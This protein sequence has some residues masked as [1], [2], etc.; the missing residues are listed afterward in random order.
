MTVFVGI[1][2][3]DSKFKGYLHQIIMVILINVPTIS[4]GLA[5]GWVSLASGEGQ[6]TDETE[7][8]VAAA[9]TFGAS[10][11]GVPISARAIA[12][13]RKPAVI[14]ISAAFV[15]C[16][17]LKLMGD[18]WWLVA[19]RIAAG[20]GG[21]GAWSVSPL[22]AR[23][24]CELKF[25]GAAVAAS[26]LAHNI[27]FLLMYLAADASL[28]HRSS[29]EARK[30]LAWLRGVHHEDPSLV[31][32]MDSLPLPEEPVQSPIKLTKEMLSDVNRR[33]AFVVSSIAVIGQEMCGVFALLQ[34]AERVFVLTRDHSEEDNVLVTP[35]RH[36]VI[37]GVVQLIASAV[38][39]YLVERIGRRPLLVV[40]SVS[41]GICLTTAAIAVWLGAAS[42]WAAALLAGAVAFDSA[43]MQPAP[44]A[45]LA[46][47]FHYQYRGCALMIVSALG[48]IG[49]ASEMFI[50]PLVTSQWG[51]EAALG[52][53]GLLTSA[54]AVFVIA[55]VPETKGK[56]PE[57]IYGGR[58]NDEG[59]KNKCSEQTTMGLLDKLSIW[60]GK[61][62]TEVT[63]LVLGLDN[64][65]KSTLLNTLRPQEQRAQYLGPTVAN[66]QEQFSSGGVS[67]TAWDVSGAPR[68]RALWER[69]YRRAHAVIFVVDSA[70]HLRLVVAREELELMLAHPDMF[71][72]RIPLLVFANKCDSPH[73]LAPMQI[74]AA[75]CLER[76]TDKP[77]HICAS[78]ALSGAGLADGVA[79]LAR[80]IRD[81]HLPH[82][83]H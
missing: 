79:W 3:K 23:E 14:G 20:L 7:V 2:I 60:L 66:Q 74:A 78:N 26:V 37:L 54:Y 43:G 25:R 68:H 65:G 71:G 69:H 63:V 49:N 80:Q 62:R 22:L 17:T 24:M 53:A 34:F 44:Y 1:E 10:F 36:A 33:K 18:G 55:A 13:G 57:E 72:R 45:L 40:C 61:G 76:V 39:L 16:W 38:A 51:I 56:T 4:F 58:N 21:A 27:G 29:S 59:T 42:G 15:V 82:D 46:D 19:A 28:Q 64:S 81:A 50:F 41:T 70:D 5:M 6:S 30:S 32:E 67:F 75:L 9:T 12:A 77:W 8:V 47:M 48:H 31:E 73:A 11:L 35:A 83:K 52:V